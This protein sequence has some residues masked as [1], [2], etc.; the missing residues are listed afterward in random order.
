MKF[1]GFVDSSVGQRFELSRLFSALLVSF[2]ALTVVF[3]LAGC[4]E[5][6]QK[7]RHGE[8]QVAS[9]QEREQQYRNLIDQV[10]RTAEAQENYPDQTFLRGALGR[11]NKWLA[12]K[13]TS[14]DFVPDPEYD[15]LRQRFEDLSK[16]AQTFNDVFKRFVDESQSVEEKDCADLDA[17]LAQ[18]KSSL[19]TLE[20]DCKSNALGVF[21]IILE[22]LEGK[23]SA[24]KEVQ[25][26]DPTE[27]Y[28]ALVQQLANSPDYEVFNFHALYEGASNYARLLDIDSKNFLPQDADY[29]RS[30]V[31]CRDVFNWAKGPKQDDM[32][33]VLQLFDWTVK[34]VVLSS[35]IVVQSR[36]VAQLEWQTL[37]L[38]QGSPVDRAIV[39]IELLRQH[40]L[41]AFVVRPEGKTPENFPVVVGVRLDGETYLFDMGYGLPYVSASADALALDDELAFNKVATL[42]E[43]AKDDAILRAFDLP[44]RVYPATSADF[45]KVVAYVP[46]TPFHVAS[47]M[48]PMEQEFSGSVS[49]VL[50][51]PF[52]I[53]KER[54]AALDRVADVRRLQEANAAILE[55][56]IFPDEADLM[57]KVFMLPLENA[58]N[59][60]VTTASDK[61]NSDAIEDY[62]GDSSAQYEGNV[63]GSK[64]SILAPLWIGKI[65]YLRGKFVDDS[66]AA[67][68][69]L[70]G[71]VS[72]RILKKRESNIPQLVEKNLQDYV[73]WAQSQGQDVSQD[74]LRRLANETALTYQLEIATKRY[75]KLLTSYELAV[76]SYA[77]ASYDAAMERLNDD[78]LRY[79]RSTNE[80]ISGD[81]IRNAANYL[82]GRLLER[83][84]EWSAAASRL[85]SGRDYGSMVRAKWI[86]QIANIPLPASLT[87]PTESNGDAAEPDLQNVTGATP[88][89]STQAPAPDADKPVEETAP[90]PQATVETTPED[91]T[92]APAPDADKPVEETAPEPQATVETTSEDATHAPA[93]DAGEPVEETAPEPQETVE[94]TSED[95]LP[96]EEPVADEPQAPADET[97]VEEPANQI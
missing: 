42:R 34:N 61:N 57:T 77:N 66:G 80:M 8:G 58:A 53:Q 68:W 48:I 21:R 1:I 71:R 50:S 89:D 69:L 10:V 55:Q 94:T 11:L 22:T 67:H 37:L 19:K 28:R 39:F 6:E 12:A 30:I 41:D 78:S 17:A 91:A 54:I 33:V 83:K 81:E 35:P 70:Q 73:Q 32:A 26:A 16:S 75:V 18:L 62:T 24:T 7:M 95:A 56:T 38:G 60:D 4:K 9:Q 82:C 52:D 88:E 40:R 13:P 92:Q 45:Q 46:S 15:E 59:L 64:K 44:V 43:A 90:D 96:L 31:W 20:T 97:A 5:K 2:C 14:P 23:L 72:D 76:L 65:L 3:S 27:S 85:A 93:S 36:P 29:L 25:F 74:D 86:A 51:T 87:E 47:R 79:T 63:S 84:A 49:T